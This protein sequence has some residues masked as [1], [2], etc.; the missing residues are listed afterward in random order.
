MSK[1]WK[2]N[3]W[4]NFINAKNLFKIPN[5]VQRETLAVANFGELLDKIQLWRILWFLWIENINITVFIADS[6]ILIYQESS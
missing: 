3:Y 6:V 5:I 2:Y 4:Y 1:N